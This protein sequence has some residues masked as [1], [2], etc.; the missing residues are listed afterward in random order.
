MGNEEEEEEMM[1]VME[2]GE[3]RGRNLIRWKQEMVKPLFGFGLFPCTL[4]LPGNYNGFCSKRGIGLML[5][6]MSASSG[7]SRAYQLWFARE[8]AQRT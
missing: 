3:R 8:D 2:I 5:M 1:G 6:V 7:L 4:C